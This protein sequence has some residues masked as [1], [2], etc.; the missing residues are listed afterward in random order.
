MQV[1]KQGD[2]GFGLGE[3]FE[4]ESGLTLAGIATAEKSKQ[5]TRRKILNLVNKFVENMTEQQ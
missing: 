3:T 4:L 2:N 5:S 1:K